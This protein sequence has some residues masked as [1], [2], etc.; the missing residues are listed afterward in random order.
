MAQYPNARISEFAARIGQGRA[1]QG[2]A[3][4]LDQVLSMLGNEELN[5][6]R[7]KFFRTVVFY[8]DSRRKAQRY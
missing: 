3:E 5:S 1:N 6:G 7:S 8:Q 2:T 4:M